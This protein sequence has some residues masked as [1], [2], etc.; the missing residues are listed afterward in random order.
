M[1]KIKAIQYFFIMLGLLL[2]AAS[3]D[4]GPENP[5]IFP[6]KGVFILSEGNF[7]WNNSSLSLYNPDSASVQNNIFYLA[8][9]APLGDVAQSMT[10]YGDQAFIAVNG[11]GK[12]YVIDT[13]TFTYKGKI[14]GLSSPRYIAIAE[15]GKAYISDLYAKEILVFSPDSLQTLKRINL[16]HSSEQLLLWND[17]LF[18]ASWSYDSLLFKIDTNTDEV[19]DSVVVG[20]Q[21]NSMQLDANGKIWLLCDGGY[22]GIPGGKQFPC[23]T[24]VD[25]ETMSILRRLQFS[26]L[27]SSPVELQ[28][29]PVGDTL[30]Y[31]NQGLYAFGI[32]QEYLPLLAKIPSDEHNWYALGVDPHQGDL[33]LGDAVSYVQPGYCY[34]YT[35]DYQLL[36]SFMVGINPGFFCFPATQL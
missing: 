11:S 34:R 25:P 8:N 26:S 20:F 16:N 17:F 15:N 28:R 21:P 18:S 13:E 32:T 1:M 23:L 6:S 31:L 4:D 2:T 7:S 24:Q 10:I 5:D 27:E 9:E 29:N 30:Y 12:I 22:P 14:T 19:I 33:Y 36:D 3:C 35:S